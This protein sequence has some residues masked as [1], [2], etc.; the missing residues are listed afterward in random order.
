MNELSLYNDYL[1]DLKTSHLSSQTKRVYASRFRQFMRFLADS[2]SIEPLPPMHQCALFL[3]HLRDTEQLK[4]T[5]INAYRSSLLH[6]MTHAGILEFDLPARLT[7]EPLPAK[8]LTREEFSQYIHAAIAM[9][10][11]RDTAIV[12]FVALEG[13]G[14]KRCS[15]LRISDLVVEESQ[16]GLR[17][18]H[19]VTVQCDPL[20]GE[21]LLN[22]R[23]NL[24]ENKGTDDDTPVFLTRF[25]S[26]LSCQTID[27]VIR[28]VGFQCGLVVCAR[29]LRYSSRAYAKQSNHETIL[30]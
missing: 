5:S 25:G 30:Q 27:Y 28:S 4:A 21:A 7:T 13:L 22:Y 29:T 3:Q 26:A 23:P 6:C 11:A 17:V 8:L 10:N 12:F 24:V 1:S 19:A 9:K 16:I 2:P 15:S 14:P 18:G 20:T